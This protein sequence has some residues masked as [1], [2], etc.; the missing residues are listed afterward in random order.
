MMGVL[1]VTTR[2]CAVRLDL[3]DLGV[4]AVKPGQ[5][6]LLSSFTIFG[7]PGAGKTT[8][9]C[10]AVEVEDLSPVLVLDFE[11]SCAAVNDKYPEHPDIDIIPLRNWTRARDVINRV[12][13]SDH[14]Y[15]TIILDPINGLSKMLQI[16]MNQRVETKRKLMRACELGQISA[17]ELKRLL[18]EQSLMA[19]KVP[20]ATNNSLGEASTTQADYGVIG[21]KLVEI[22][23]GFVQSP[24]LA[25]FVTHTK[26]KRN[27]RGQ[28]IAIGPDMA[29]SMAGEELERKPGLV[30][31]LQM[32]TEQDKS[33][34]IREST[35]IAFHSGHLRG[36][37][38]VAKRRGR[39]PARLENPT[40]AMIHEH[41]TGNAG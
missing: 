29:G 21:T 30:G 19:V 10:S 24:A 33:G 26:V 22:I 16:H 41:V 11:D 12:L 38:Y 40:M 5:I 34:Q 8:L 7:P 35:S 14:G 39:V 36:L 1:F 3:S 17:T 20:E 37:P 28:D 25:V 2:G 13:T 27:D 18:T 23:Q 32:H 6:P 31:L 9:A 15:R 4:E